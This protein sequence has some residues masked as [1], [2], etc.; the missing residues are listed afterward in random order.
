MHNDCM[1]KMSL[2]CI[3]STEKVKVTND[4]RQLSYEIVR[5]IHLFED[6]HKLHKQNTN[7]TPKLKD[8][9]K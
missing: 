9:K 2:S 4:T 5:A 1:Q 8:Y 7:N 3:F 6:K